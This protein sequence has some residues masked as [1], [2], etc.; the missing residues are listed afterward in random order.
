MNR[1]FILSVVLLFSIPEFA[2]SQENDYESDFE[3]FLRYYNSGDLLKAEQYLLSSLESS[4]TLPV[5]YNIP[6]LNNLGAVN[7]L[8]GRY[9]RSLDYY[10]KAELLLV[11]EDLSQSLGDIYI[12][13][14][15]ILGIQKSYA[16]AFEYFERGI[17]IY[18]KLV[19]KDKS[20][21][22]SLS[23]AYMNYGRI[24]TENEEYQHALKLL[25]KSAALIENNKLSTLANVYLNIAQVCQNLN[26]FRDAELYYHKCIRILKEK[27]TDQYYRLSEAYYSYARLLGIE[28]RKTE[29]FEMLGMAL[30]ISLRNYGP[31]SPQV[32][33]VYK[34][35]GDHFSDQSEYRKALD[36]Y[37]KALISIVDSFDETDIF[38]NPSG[39]S[40]LFAI[41]LLDNLKSKALAIQ[42][43]ALKEQ[44]EQSAIKYSKAASE[45]IGI[46]L[47]VLEKIKDELVS[48]EDRIYLAENE[49]ETYISAIDIINN[50]LKLTGETSLIRKMYTFLQ[51]TKAS[52]L[53][54][55]IFENELLFS[56]FISDSL[57]RRKN[58]L[59]LALGSYNKFILNEFQNQRPDTAK[60]NLW[61][62]EIFAM[63]RE[64]EK[65]SVELR[66]C[67]PEYY[68]LLEK[69]KPLSVAQIMRGLKKDETI[70][71]FILSRESRNGIRKLFTFIIT[72]DS[73]FLHESHLDSLFTINTE[74]IRNGSRIRNNDS[75]H[76]L[77]LNEY[78]SALNFMYIK[79]I[80]PVL[81]NL[82]TGHLII[83]PDDEIALLPFDALIESLPS[84]TIRSFDGLPY[85]INKYTISYGPSSSLVFNKTPRSRK[86]YAFS[87]DY[88]E[89][90][91]DNRS[92]V[93]LAG[94]NKEI[95][96]IFRWF[97]GVR[98]TGHSA[99]EANFRSSLVSPGIFH[100]AMHSVSDTLDSK[101]SCLLFGTGNDSLN[102]GKLYNYEVS[103]LK[104]ASPMIVLSSCN[105]GTGRLYH[106][107]GLISLARGFF[108]AGASSVIMTSWEINDEVSAEIMTRFYY[109]LAK[110]KQKD[111]AMRR[112]KLDF[113][114]N[115]PP[116]LKDPYYWAAYKVMGNNDP[117]TA[118]LNLRLFAVS[119]IT[120]LI[121]VSI[122]YYF[123]RRRILSEGSL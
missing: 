31:K 110:G 32:S 61:K 64:L 96:A 54:E 81:K 93:H 20:V 49:K 95:D 3:N 105:S 86:V 34:H 41:R 56:E 97:R 13:K 60:I 109:N 9:D 84:E 76:S 25:H 19:I 65:L 71:D 15:I 21:I 58:D 104:V 85:L 70:I 82:N 24:L 83:I 16:N 73:L 43:L 77:L 118:A 22:L 72:R 12:N 11:A 45:T 88:N 33:L 113:L 55:E 23:L 119:A 57:L 94:A 92:H 62:D 122:F 5:S 36:Y 48:D 29:A 106:S 112:A 38:S 90:N 2:L 89:I 6:L 100:L 67:Y 42:E 59:E 68:N 116:S 103:L 30:S 99:T 115:N 108:L 39:D 50:E 69:T 114:I 46:A 107:E 78:A 66:S 111:E 7:F 120:I 44:N 52:L 101:Y 1:L 91:S 98:F 26:E 37:Q 51:D 40:S 28:G 63:N 4:D 47:H 10:N 18:D 80:S 17:R 79:L 87:P 14:A 121:A 75:N 123:R 102:D 8:L 27:Y 117:V 74:I 53:R 35:L